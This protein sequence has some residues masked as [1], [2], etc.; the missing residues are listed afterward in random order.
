[1]IHSL[2][3]HHLL[4]RQSLPRSSNPT[5][6]FPMNIFTVRGLKS[7]FFSCQLLPNSIFFVFARP[8]WQY[9]VSYECRFFQKRQINYQETQECFNTQK[10]Y[11]IIYVIV[12]LPHKYMYIPSSGKWSKKLKSLIFI[13]M[14]VY[15]IDTKSKKEHWKWKSVCIHV[16]VKIPASWAL[17]SKQ[18]NS[19]RLS[20]TGSYTQW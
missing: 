4:S 7:D 20:L 13:C 16:Y 11:Y 18:T 6:F 15:F 1:M 8:L 3:N 19:D 9:M 2:Q 14:S 17:Y 12:F 10:K 5:V